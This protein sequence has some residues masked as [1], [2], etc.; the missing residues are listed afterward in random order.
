MSRIITAREV[1]TRWKGARRRRF[2]AW[3]MAEGID[4]NTTAE[5]ILNDDGSVAVVSF[6]LGDDGK[7]QL[8]PGA[9]EIL[10]SRSKVRPKTQCPEE[11]R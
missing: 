2:I 4:P 8:A 5:I 11:E 10:T 1:T 7:R 3:L 6:V 9:N